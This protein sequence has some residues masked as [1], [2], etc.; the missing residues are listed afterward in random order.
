V[1]LLSAKDVRKAYPHAG[2][3]VR[4]V[5]LDIKQG[6]CVALVGPS[7]AGKSTL[8][9]CLAT[10]DQPDAG[11]I[12]LHVEGGTVDLAALHG[13]ALART[14]ANHLGMI[15]Q[16]HHLLPEFTALENVM[17][18]ALIKGTATRDASDMARQLLTK[19]NLSH[20]EQHYPT[21]LSG[22][23]QQRVAIARALVNKPAILFADE[24][25]GNLDSANA[26]AIATLFFELQAEFGLSCIIATHSAELAHRCNRVLNMRDGV[27]VNA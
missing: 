16:F 24:P 21:Q 5:S 17:V 3:V 9:H 6:E 11:T 26:E 13:A 23:E 19:V 2:V 22:G 4:D 25:T 7:G 14:R 20:R 8:L 15:Y 12:L 27:I 1:I 10:L 18:P